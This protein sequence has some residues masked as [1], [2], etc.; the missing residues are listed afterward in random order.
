MAE[1]KMYSIQ[2]FISETY[3]VMLTSEAKIFKS[4]AQL[5]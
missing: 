5:V 1:L 3:Y 4:I 2:P